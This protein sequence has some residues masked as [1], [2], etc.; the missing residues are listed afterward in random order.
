MESGTA[1]RTMAFEDEHFRLLGL[2][3]AAA[4]RHPE[5]AE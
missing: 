2:A 1:D 4:L 3:S 5:Q